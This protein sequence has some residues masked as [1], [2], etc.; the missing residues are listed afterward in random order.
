MGKRA[1]TARRAGR[2]RG[3]VWAV[4]L[5]AACGLAPPAGAVDLDA[6]GRISF[7]ARLYSQ[8]GLRTENSQIQTFPATKTGQL[9]QH[10]NFYSPELDARLTS[11]L[12]WMRGGSLQWL[13]PDDLTFRVAAWGFYDGIYDY[14]S[15]QFN[16]AQ[17]QINSGY[18][19]PS[20]QT[21]TFYL[22]G[23]EF[24]CASRDA[25]GFCVSSAGTRVATVG[26]LF[27]NSHVLWPRDIYS[28]QQR[29]NELYLTYSK[30]PLFL[31]I[32][33]QSISWGESDTIALLDQNNPFDVT[34]GVPG[35]LQ[36][37]DE[38]RIPLWTVRS[39]FR[40]F[41]TVGPFTSGFVEAYWVP[42]DVD[43]NTG[44]AP[45]RAAS[46]YSP[47]GPDPQAV[48]AA[49]S[50]G[51]LN[52]QFVFLNRVPA[53]TMSNS[54]W[55]VRL[56]TVVARD[57]TV[58]VFFY[59]LFPN[60]P[61]PLGRG[62]IPTDQSGSRL[63]VTEL[64][65]DLTSA[66]AVTDTFFLA[67]LDGIVRLELEYFDNEPAFIPQANLGINADT[68]ANP[69]LTLSACATR[70][71]GSNPCYTPKAD[72][73]RWEVGFDRFFFL[74]ALNPTNSFSLV[75][76]L[77]GSWN[78]DETSRK[79][80]RF[81]GQLKPGAPGN[82]PDDFVQLKKV[83]GFVQAHLQTDYLHGLLVPGLTWIQNFRGTY[84]LQPS[85]L[86]RW[87]DW[88]LLSLTYTTIGGEFQ[89]IGFYRDRDQ[90]SLRATY[91]LN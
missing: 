82:A 70:P 84:A 47:P 80:F 25:S 42:G 58:S 6:A 86:Y 90:L 71:D 4:I 56:Q 38:A 55:G 61:V 89:Q 53:T 52:T 3:Q 23:D 10:R 63:F 14:G 20:V 32:G 77:V 41:D 51:I 59:R 11:Y 1:Q 35:L 29:V 50:G 5:L 81:N 73:L 2:H 36:D 7:R 45:L 12:D 17:R 30:G 15:S 62:L 75:T 65:H 18:P 9:V 60:S 76:S 54:R 67:P 13:A 34:L 78:L 74:R 46:P 21:G 69:I 64:A 8:A 39:T 37:L 91:Q 43:T 87:A 85:V 72:F 33:R 88:L 24:A 26:S 44:Y 68:A 40:L 31:R 79:D 16:R 66:V 83:E 28:T 22:E 49:Q 27:P 19:D 57:H 48:L